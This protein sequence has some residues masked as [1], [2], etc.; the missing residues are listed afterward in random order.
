MSKRKNIF[1]KKK[2]LYQVFTRSPEFQVDTEVQPVYSRPIT[3]P[4]FKGGPFL[5]VCLILTDHAIKTN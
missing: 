5:S 4:D 3:S 1:E 2:G